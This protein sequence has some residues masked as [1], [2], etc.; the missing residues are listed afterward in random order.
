MKE[1]KV[2]EYESKVEGWKKE[3]GKVFK[4]TTEDGDI[5]IWR[6]LKRKEYVEVMSI[7]EEMEAM[8]KE[9]RMY[10]RQDKI[11]KMVTL[12]PEDLS[13][14]DQSAGLATSISD[15]VI[16]KSGFGEIETAEL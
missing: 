2:N 7:T 9:Q 14:F 6:R 8:D 4:T 1:I 16:Y 11:A 10:D 13:I 15:E 12:Y 3:F 5:F